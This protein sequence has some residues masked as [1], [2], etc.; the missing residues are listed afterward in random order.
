MYAPVRT[1]EKNEHNQF[2]LIVQ[3]RNKKSC[4]RITLY[5]FHYLSL[6]NGTL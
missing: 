1:D 6:A 5:L 4:K 3:T 2:L